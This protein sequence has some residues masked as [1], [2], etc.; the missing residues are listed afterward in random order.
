MLISRSLRGSSRDDCSESGLLDP[1]L[2]QNCF[3]FQK[4]AYSVRAPQY[5]LQ[6]DPALPFGCGPGMFAF[7]QSWDLSVLWL[8]FVRFLKIYIYMFY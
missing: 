7:L 5:H 2:A 6:E 8:V 4:A 1:W 3:A